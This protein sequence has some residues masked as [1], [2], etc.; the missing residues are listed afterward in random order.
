M[1]TSAGMHK[2]KKKKKQVGLHQS[3]K[4]LYGKGNN[5][6]GER[7]TYQVGENLYKSYIKG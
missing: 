2:Q 4:L 1:P 3:K 6:E 7:A 5:Q